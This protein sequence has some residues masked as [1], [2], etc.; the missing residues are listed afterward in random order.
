MARASLFF[1]LIV[2]ALLILWLR[3]WYLQIAQ[4]E[5]LELKAQS[6]RTRF[7]RIAPPRGAIVD[8]NG[9]P[10]AT[11]KPLVF[12]VSV[13][14][15]EAKRNPDHLHLIANLLNLDFNKLKADVESPHV[16]PFAPVII[17]SG[18][19]Y[20][21]AVPVFEAQH[22]FPE[23]RVWMDSPRSYPLGSSAAHLIGYVGQVSPDELKRYAAMSEDEESDGNLPIA[24]YDG[25]DLVGKIGVEHRYELRLHGQPG[26]ERVEVTPKGRHA[27]VLETIE[28]ER[29]E[30]LALTID[31]SLQQLAYQLL[32]DKKVR[33]A[34]VAI[35]PRNGAVI[36]LTS[37]P[38]YNPNLF[39]GR[40]PAD[41][42][43]SLTN[44]RSAPLQH[45]AIQSA[46]A[47]GSIYKMVTA[48]SVLETG[49]M[50][51]RNTVTCRGGT[52]LG[53]RFFKCHAVHG[54]V[55]MLGAIA[56]SC[57][58]YFYEAARR[59]GPNRLAEYS[60]MFGLGAPTGIDLPHEGKGLVPDEEWKRK[61]YKQAW[62]GGDTF[63]YGIGQG[64]LQTTPIQMAQMTC[65]VA[66]R[67]FA[68]APRLLLEAEPQVAIKPFGQAAHWELVHRGM[69]SVVS[70]GTARSVTLPGIQVA[71]KT[72]S[73]EFRKGGKTHSWFV[74]YAPADKPEIALVVMA[75]EAGHGGTIAAPIAKA[76]LEAYFKDKRKAAGARTAT[77]AN[78][79]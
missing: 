43:N 2:V 25:G 71:G 45:R 4:G 68:Y 22:R 52:Q 49:L 26:G 27:R 60:R 31:A 72:G 44:D 21:Q 10:L 9:L 53:T 46:Y 66:N 63:N 32:V 19:S 24:R 38:A 20:Q 11:N 76:W 33:G 30:R 78:A 54:T 75:E 12:V 37:R 34:L 64:F 79:L 58:S 7:V 28:S 18:L 1:G 29:G 70:S 57:D 77:P 59:A 16:N 3:L 55:N 51:P 5:Q 62:Y 40:I 67:G 65:V 48:M 69:V 23:L 42:W 8:R 73:A 39:V 14:P 47:P 36:A 13:V 50:S 74:A 6:A 35:D 61:R 17:A 15:Y 56:H 41:L